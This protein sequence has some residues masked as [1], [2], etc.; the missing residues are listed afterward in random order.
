MIGVRD[1]YMLEENTRLTEDK[2]KEITQK[3]FSYVLVYR[4]NRSTVVGAIKIK[5]FAVRCLQSDTVLRAGEVM[6]PNANMLTVYEDTNLLHM[7]MI[8]QAKSTRVALV[9]NLKRKLDP[10]IESIM[11]SVLLP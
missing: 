11:Y 1:F 10:T 3:D 6:K 7:L 2:I 5:E 9:C 8:F 4:E